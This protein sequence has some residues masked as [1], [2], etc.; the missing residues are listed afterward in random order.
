MMANSRNKRERKKIQQRYTTLRAMKIK[1]KPLSLQDLKGWQFLPSHCAT[2]PVNR[3]PFNRALMAR[4][5]PGSSEGLKKLSHF[6]EI[7]MYS[8]THVGNFMK[9]P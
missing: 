9:T 5:H 7:K 2:S 8:S 6:I 4:I 3:G 1:C